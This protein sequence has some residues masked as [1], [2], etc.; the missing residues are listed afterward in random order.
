MVHAEL[1]E[2]KDK[3]TNCSAM[4][5]CDESVDEESIK[6][7]IFNKFTFYNEPYIKSNK[8]FIVAIHYSFAETMKFYAIET[9]E[10]GDVKN[11]FCIDKYNLKMIFE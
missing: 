1:Y 7:V 8:F 11:I 10:N 9:D 4:I 6:N 5:E 2:V 3:I